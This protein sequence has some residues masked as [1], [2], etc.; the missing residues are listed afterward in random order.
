MRTLFVKI[1]SVLF[2]KDAGFILKLKNSEL[3]F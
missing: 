2:M 1:F 3:S